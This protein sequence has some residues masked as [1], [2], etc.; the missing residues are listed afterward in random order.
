M[1][2]RLQVVEAELRPS[3][4]DRQTLDSRLEQVAENVGDLYMYQRNHMEIFRYRMA[5]ARM[6]QLAEQDR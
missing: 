3:V 5:D 6:D 4:T 2:P 1:A